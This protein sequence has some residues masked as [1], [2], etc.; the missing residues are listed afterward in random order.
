M[1]LAA[2][3]KVNARKPPINRV[4]QRRN[5]YLCQIE[6]SFACSL[7]PGYLSCID[8]GKLQF[9]GQRRIYTTLTCTCVNQ[10]R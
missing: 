5:I 4:F 9:L 2:R 8:C 7:H 10:C 6:D 3:C 1:R